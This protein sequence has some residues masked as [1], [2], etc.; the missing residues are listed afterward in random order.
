M[1]RCTYGDTH[2][3]TEW[4]PHSW[5]DTAQTSMWLLLEKGHESVE[6]G[7]LAVNFLCLSLCPSPP[8]S[9]HSCWFRWNKQTNCLFPCP[10]SETLCLSQDLWASLSPSLQLRE[11]GGAGGLGWACVCFG[12]LAWTSLALL[13]SPTDFCKRSDW[14]VKPP[15]S[16]NQQLLAW[17]T[18]DSPLVFLPTSCI[19]HCRLHFTEE[20]RAPRKIWLIVKDH[21]ASPPWATET[22]VC[23]VTIVMLF[24]SCPSP[25][26][27]LL[28]LDPHQLHTL[29][30]QLSSVPCSLVLQP[31]S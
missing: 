2:T 18:H 28:T 23:V 5:K 15:M 14:E 30:P 9:L 29:N 16:W 13:I 10:L 20:D 8:R 4:D 17:L 21:T 22:Q 26:V 12:C 31:I 25:S 19:S 3:H 27:L 24:V 1:G 11:R 6:E 7:G